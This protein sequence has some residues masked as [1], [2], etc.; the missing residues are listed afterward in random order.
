MLTDRLKLELRKYDIVGT[1]AKRNIL[2]WLPQAHTEEEV[3]SFYKEATALTKDFG[4]L[5]DI[6]LFTETVNKI[7]SNKRAFVNICNSCGFDHNILIKNAQAAEFTVEIPFDT[8]LT[9]KRHVTLNMMYDGTK[10]TDDMFLSDFKKAIQS[11]CAKT[12]VHKFNSATL[13]RAIDSCLPDT[14]VPACHLQ[15]IK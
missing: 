15:V 13:M 3:F 7:A 9:E 6:E 10:Y 11:D 1:S 4:I 5:A 2:Y 8:M 14:S 12:R